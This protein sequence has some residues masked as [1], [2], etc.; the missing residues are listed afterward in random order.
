MEII[1]RQDGVRI[2]KS[3]KSKEDLQDIDNVLRTIDIISESAFADNEFLTEI[4]IPKNVIRICQFAF[5][6]CQNLKRVSLSSSNQVGRFA[7][8]NCGLEGLIIED[9]NLIQSDAFRECK[10][11]K[12]VEI[13]SGHTIAS[14][15]F[16]RCSNLKKV[17]LPKEIESIEDRAFYRCE[18]LEETDLLNN[19]RYIGSEAFAHTGLLIVKVNNETHIHRDAFGS[20]IVVKRIDANNS[21]TKNQFTKGTGLVSEMIIQHTVQQD[22][23]GEEKSKDIKSLSSNIKDNVFSK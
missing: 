4:D 19:I 5:A 20:A 23:G 7:F 11:L 18:N 3:C 12:E 10:D 9:S 8:Y 16:S 13:R 14:R 2:L 15:C 21:S 1:Y 6:R 17:I 22:L